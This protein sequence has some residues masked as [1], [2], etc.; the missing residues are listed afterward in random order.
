[1]YA[2]YS[3]DTRCPHKISICQ[4][5]FEIEYKFDPERVVTSTQLNFQTPLLIEMQYRLCVHSLIYY[6]AWFGCHSCD[7]IR[8]YTCFVTNIQSDPCRWITTNAICM[9]VKPIC[10][11]TRMHF[12]TIFAIHSIICPSLLMHILGAD[13]LPQRIFV[14]L[15][16]WNAICWNMLELHHCQVQYVRL[17]F[18]SVPL[19]AWT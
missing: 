19:I 14:A 12:T 16:F 15:S 17:N 10:H 18:H 13:S 9:F 7:A 1:M 4:Q 8:L 11:R 3:P 6:Y 2:K 5:L